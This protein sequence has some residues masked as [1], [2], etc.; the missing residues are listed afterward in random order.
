MMNE[1]LQCMTNTTFMLSLLLGFSVALNLI[2]AKRRA[3]TELNTQARKYK[4]PISI[5]EA[6]AERALSIFH[7]K[8]PRIQQVFQAKVIEC[9]KT[10]R[11]LIAPIPY[12]IDA[13]LGGKRTFFERMGDELFRQGFSYLP[14]RA[15]SDN[16]KAAALRIQYRIPTIK[17]VMEAHDALLFSMPISKKKE[18]IPIIKQEMER[19][20]DFSRCSLP[21]H[22]LVI[23]CDIECG[24][25]YR[26]LKKFKDFELPPAFKS[27]MPPPKP[28]SITEQFLAP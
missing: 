18:W 23:P 1:L 14:Q 10:N 24:K 15:V 3:A 22:E 13:S 4:I 20:I 25:D 6:I 12:G 8:S 27:V 7:S 9:L 11:Q 19:P 5:T 26:N 2:I 16:T 17:I 21:R 28:K